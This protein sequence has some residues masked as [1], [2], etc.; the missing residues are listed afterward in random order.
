MTR[1]ADLNKMCPACTAGAIGTQLD[2]LR[3]AIVAICTNIDT[4]NGT[5]GA[6]YVTNCVTAFA[7]AD[8]GI[9]DLVTK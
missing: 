9:H 6:D 3:S 8:D 1:A 7:L 2:A 5:I 4:D